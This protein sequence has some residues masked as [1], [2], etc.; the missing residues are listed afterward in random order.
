MYIFLTE[1]LS[2]LQLELLTGIVRKFCFNQVFYILKV[3]FK[4]LN[5]RQYQKSVLVNM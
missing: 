3:K 1:T 2:N 5:G 4:L